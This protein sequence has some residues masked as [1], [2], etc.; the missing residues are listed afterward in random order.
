M[1]IIQCPEC[2][3]DVSTTAK[4]C[5]HCGYRL[6]KPYLPLTLII[7]AIMAICA[8]GITFFLKKVDS[9]ILTE[10]KFNE[11]TNTTLMYQGWAFSIPKCF[12]KENS[13]DKDTRVTYQ[14]TETNSQGALLVFDSKVVEKDESHNSISN[15]LFKEFMLNSSETKVFYVSGL[16]GTIKKG[17]AYI[18]KKNMEFERFE[19]F[20]AKTNSMI[21]VLMAQTYE[22]K[23]DYL[24]DFEKIINSMIRIN[25]MYDAKNIDNTDNTDN[26]EI[27][28]NTDN[29]D[30]TEIT[31]NTDNTDNTGITSDTEITDITDNN[32]VGKQVFVTEALSIRDR[33]SSDG[34]KIGSA[35]NG[36]RYTITAIPDEEWFQIDYKG[37]IGYVR[38][39]V[40][41]V[42]E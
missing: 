17:K 25:G 15:S 41:K 32:I 16:T 40:V 21:Y 37:M 36:D 26:I 38:Q 39:N 19:F 27:T 42:T 3:N 31:S 5:P 11:N 6:K 4:V 8:V 22:T 2:N 29:T 12:L 10:S 28:S 34:E 7:I 24:S 23:Y 30:N 9:N 20:D 14:L 18:N 1:A 35:Y 13:S 33:P